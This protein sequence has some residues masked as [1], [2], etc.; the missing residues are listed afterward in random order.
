MEQRTSPRGSDAPNVPITAL[1]A[2][3]VLA[4]VLVS[5]WAGTRGD[6]VA[7]LGTVPVAIAGV[8]LVG[9][10]SRPGGA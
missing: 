5:A 6:V 7:V 9:V 1:G 3:V 4:S 2:L 10:G 8:L